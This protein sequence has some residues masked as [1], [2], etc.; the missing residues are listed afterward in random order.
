MSFSAFLPN[1]FVSGANGGRFNGNQGCGF[2]SL[3]HAGYQTPRTLCCQIAHSNS[4]CCPMAQG[5]GPAPSLPQFTTDEYFFQG[6]Q[7]FQLMDH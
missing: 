5:S 7:G 3:G 2:S 6:P 4:P 1:C